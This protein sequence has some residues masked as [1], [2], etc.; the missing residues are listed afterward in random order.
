MVGDMRSW[1]STDDERRRARSTRRILR[2]CGKAGRRIQDAEHHLTIIL[3]CTGII[4][5]TSITGCYHGIV[6]NCSTRW[7]GEKSLHATF[8]TNEETKTAVK[9]S[10]LRVLPFDIAKQHGPIHRP[11][12]ASSRPAILPVSKT[13]VRTASI[14]KS[15]LSASLRE[16]RY[17][18]RT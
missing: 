10:M 18:R 6:S 7:K 11:C 14:P 3:L 2:Q 5:L 15:F 8:E 13:R 9:V 4:I 12:A 16:V 1:T 17:R